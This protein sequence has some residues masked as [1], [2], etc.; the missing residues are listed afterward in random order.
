MH[1]QYT[2]SCQHI[3]NEAHWHKAIA[4]E[5]SKQPFSDSAR[6]IVELVPHA[7]FSPFTEPN[8]LRQVNFLSSPPTLDQAGR[9]IPASLD[10]PLL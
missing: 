1:K 6:S 8:F 7:Q 2:Y 4:I 10:L 5:Q 9:E 3:K